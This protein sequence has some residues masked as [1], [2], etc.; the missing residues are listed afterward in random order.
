MRA[1]F[2]PRDEILAEVAGE[3]D[4]AVVELGGWLA[5]ANQLR[6]SPDELRRRRGGSKADLIRLRDTLSRLAPQLG[7]PAT[8]T[9]T[10]ELRGK[11][12]AAIADRGGIEVVAAQLAPGTRPA[13][14]A[15]WASD[16]RD[17]AAL[18]LA[19]SRLPLKSGQDLV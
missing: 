7:E 9:A 10:I 5:I 1:G 13:D 15:R 6:T 19:I 17:P 3:I 12:A 8:S 14:L 11:I 16:G 2:L 18:L 4:R